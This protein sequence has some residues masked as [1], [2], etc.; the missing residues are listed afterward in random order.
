MA[1]KPIPDGYRTV[2][3]YL[4]VKGLSQ[5]L[6]FVEK[7]FDA[8]NVNKMAMPDGTIRHAEFR[9]GDC[10]L[11]GGEAGDKWPPTPATLYL[12]VADTDAVY[13][14]ALAAGATSIMEPANQFYGDRNAG[15][16]DM[17][18]NFWW[19]GTHIEDVSPEEMERRMQAAG[20]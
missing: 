7:A 4:T 12:Y 18:G 9:I 1:V 16:K 20:K 5:L 2:T 10:M 19:I 14:K 11:M 6:D 17:C 13:R 3:P 15:V 8:S